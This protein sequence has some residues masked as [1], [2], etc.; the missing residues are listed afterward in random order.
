MYASG[1]PLPANFTAINNNKTERD[2]NSIT[3]NLRQLCVGI[4]NEPLSFVNAWRSN[5]LSVSRHG[6]N[7]LQLLQPKKTPHIRLNE[8]TK[9]RTAERSFLWCKNHLFI[10]V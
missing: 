4:L 1:F 7:A 10:R 5:S 6:G 8:L 3:R 2:D 9:S